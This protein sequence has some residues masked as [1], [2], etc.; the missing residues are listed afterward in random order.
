MLPVHFVPLGFQTG[1]PHNLILFY[2]FY[3]CPK[4]LYLK[5]IP[6]ARDSFFSSSICAFVYEIL[7]V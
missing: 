1:V 7:Y 2:T 5:L 3:V 6:E 4:F